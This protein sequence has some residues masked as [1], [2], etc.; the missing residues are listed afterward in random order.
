MTGYP[1]S[2]LEQIKQQKIEYVLQDIEHYGLGKVR[3]REEYMNFAGLV[4]DD[5]NAALDCKH[6]DWCNQGTLT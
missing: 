6:I 4:I 3:T 1:D 2:R 5:E